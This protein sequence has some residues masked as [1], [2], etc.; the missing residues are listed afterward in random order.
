MSTGKY[1]PSNFFPIINLSPYSIFLFLFILPSCASMGFTYDE[2]RL[3]Q[4]ASYDA[5]CPI[6]NIKVMKALDNGSA[7]TGRFLLD[8]CGKPKKYTRMGMSYHESERRW[9]QE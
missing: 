3:K 7:G 4:T 8:V 2:A 5:K 9:T 6:E 1:S